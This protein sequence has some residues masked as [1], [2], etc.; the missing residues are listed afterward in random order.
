MWLRIWFID[1]LNYCLKTII[2]IVFTFNFDLF[3][4][5]PRTAEA[6]SD[7]MM[8]HTQS[9]RSKFFLKE[10]VDKLL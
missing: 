6:Q 3:L 4:K 1:H 8:V 7:K 2:I 9:V 5:E 10:K